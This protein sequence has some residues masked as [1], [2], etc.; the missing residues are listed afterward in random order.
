MSVLEEDDVLKQLFNDISEQKTKPKEM[1]DDY[2]EPDLL[3]TE[4]KVDDKKKKVSSAK[5]MLQNKF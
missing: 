5:K 3:K 1:K 4:K 2:V